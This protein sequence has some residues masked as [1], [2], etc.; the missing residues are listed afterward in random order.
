MAHERQHSSPSTIDEPNAF[1]SLMLDNR[2]ME[3]DATEA[4]LADHQEAILEPGDPTKNAFTAAV[5]DTQWT[6]ITLSMDIL[7]VTRITPD[8]QGSITE[9]TPPLL[10]SIVLHKK[11]IHA[12]LLRLV[13]TILPTDWALA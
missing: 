6:S 10:P 1:N 2:R 4:D 12:L 9:K 11:G 3:R 7:L 13:R 5:P 8:D